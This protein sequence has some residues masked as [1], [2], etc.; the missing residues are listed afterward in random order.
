MNREEFMQEAR[1][2]ARRILEGKENGIMNLV[3]QAWAEGKWNAEVDTFTEL[4]KQAFYQVKQKD[5]ATVKISDKWISVKN[6]LP[7]PG[8]SVIIYG[9][10][11]ADPE[12]TDGKIAITW[13]SDRNIIDCQNKTTPYWIAP[14]QYFS[15]D[16]AITHW[17]PLPEPPKEES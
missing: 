3:Q 8:M 6:R 4:V 17:M 7:E 13:M 16:Y 9:T 1:E 10:P 2:T 11:K 15:F 5:T 12:H 14:W